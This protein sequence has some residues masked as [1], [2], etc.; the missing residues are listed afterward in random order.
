M[1]QV[2]LCRSSKDVFSAGFRVHVPFIPVDDIGPDV[3][4]YICIYIYIYRD[5]FKAKVY[6]TLNFKLLVHGP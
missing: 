1:V 5:Y 3:P 4:I 2:A 6:D